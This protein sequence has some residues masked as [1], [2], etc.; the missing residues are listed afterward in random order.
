MDGFYLHFTM[1]LA[2]VEGKETP[3]TSCATGARY[4]VI[5]FHIVPPLVFA[6]AHVPIRLQKVS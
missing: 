3:E 4:L 5:L 1:L 2:F 6:H